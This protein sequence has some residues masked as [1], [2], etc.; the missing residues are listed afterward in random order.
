M[1]K[2][3]LILSSSGGELARHVLP[4]DESGCVSM[5]DE[6][7]RVWMFRS[8]DMLTVETIDES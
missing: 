1:E 6:T 4:A 7:G 5:R 3:E 8:G 2:V